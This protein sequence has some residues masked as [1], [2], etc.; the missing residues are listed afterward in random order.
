[1][2]WLIEPNQITF[3]LAIV[4][5]SK[6]PLP[7]RTRYSGHV[8]GYQPIRHQCS[9][10]PDSVG[11]CE[12]ITQWGSTTIRTSEEPLPLRNMAH[13]TVLA[14]R[15]KGPVLRER[16]IQWKDAVTRNRPKQV[17]NHYKTSHTWLPWEFWRSGTD[18]HNLTT[19]QNSL[20][21]LRD[22][23]SANKRPVFPDSC[24]LP[25]RRALS[26]KALKL[27]NKQF[28]SFPNIAG[29]LRRALLLQCPQQ[30][31]NFVT[32]AVLQFPQQLGLTLFSFF[33]NEECENYGQSI[34]L[35]TGRKRRKLTHCPE[36]EVLNELVTPAL[37]LTVCKESHKDQTV[38]CN[39]QFCSF[40]NIA[41]TLRR[42]LLLQCPQQ[43]GNF[44]T[45]AVLQFPQ[46]VEFLQ[47]VKD[48]G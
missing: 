9:I 11:S 46:Q 3:L 23:L 45:K 13:S 38:S 20:F 28:C 34:G 40:P 4:V 25:M 21:R 7:I 10:F 31:G 43:R 48:A 30:R 33:S 44:V 5:I 27:Q 14:I 15:K 41:G 39:K 16:I 2:L 12:S 17:N 6:Q 42:A 24:L 32:K 1:M 18:Q 29:T 19:N 47:G 22:W 26:R 35:A 36:S 37:E 8:T